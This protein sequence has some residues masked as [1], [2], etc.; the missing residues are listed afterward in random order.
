M[1]LS[2]LCDYL[3]TH[4][5]AALIDMAHR[6]E[7]DPDALRGMLEKWIAKGRVEKL[8]LG[9]ACGNGC[10][11]CDP[12]TTEIYEWVSG[13]RLSSGQTQRHERLVKEDEAGAK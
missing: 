12:A 11:K 3:R 4:R 9:T 10:G 6:F 2:D 13:D 5:R 1:I 8:P 7:T